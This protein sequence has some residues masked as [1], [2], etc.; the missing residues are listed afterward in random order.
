[1]DIKKSEEKFLKIYDEYADA[2]FRYCYFQTSDRE[3]AKDIA[4]NT[5]IKVWTYMSSGENKIEHVK[6]FLYQVARNTVIDDRR[7]KKDFSLDKMIDDGFDFANEKDLKEEIEMIFEGE[8]ALETIKKLEE[9][10]SEI[11]TLRYVEDLS[12]KEIA[13]IT[14]ETENNVSVRIH[15]G[16]EKLKI[17]LNEN[18]QTD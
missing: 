9:K 5:F 13:K 10:Y 11:I 2:I 4:Q 6:A 12:I 17:I 14:N 16:L 18:G 8:K 7:K 3:K 1:M 15:R